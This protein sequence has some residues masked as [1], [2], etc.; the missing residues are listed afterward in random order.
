MQAAGQIPANI[1]ADTPQAAVPV[2][3]S[4]ITRQARRY[5]MTIHV[6]ERF[7]MVLMVASFVCCCF[8]LGYTLVIFRLASLKRKWWSILINKCIY[9]DLHKQLAIQ[10]WH[11]KSIWTRISPFWNS[12]KGERGVFVENSII[13]YKYLANVTSDISSF[14]EFPS[15]LIILSFH[16]INW[17]NHTGHGIRWHQL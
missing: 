16:Q 2:V 17:W 4:T 12:G 5:E 6:Y 14:Y 15:I 7:R 1:V 8:F 3:G 9:R 13:F 11:A 10:C